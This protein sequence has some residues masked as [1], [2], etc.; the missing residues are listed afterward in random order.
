MEDK[1][2]LLQLEVNPEPLILTVLL[3]HLFWMQPYSC[4][5]KEVGGEM[6]RYLH[7]DNHSFLLHLPNLAM[8]L[9]LQWQTQEL[10]G[11]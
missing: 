6:A 11:K 5:M 9:G 8:P 10:A 3:L 1:L 7:V 2:L 4:S